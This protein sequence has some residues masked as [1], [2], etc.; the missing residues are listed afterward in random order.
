M[1]GRTEHRAAAPGDPQSGPSRLRKTSATPLRSRGT[2]LEAS[3]VKATRDAGP[4]DLVYLDPPYQGTSGGRDER[5][6]ATLDRDRF[7]TYLADL[8]SRR[9][10][11]VVSFDGRTGDKPHGEPLPRD[12]GLRHV[13]LD[14]GRSS[15][16]TLLG[17]AERTVESLYLSPDL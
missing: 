1:S 11:F 10:P 13:E 15:Q 3:D 8:R 5:Y 6:A 12:L 9:V 16:S 14:A 17:R 2:S 4:G 7:V